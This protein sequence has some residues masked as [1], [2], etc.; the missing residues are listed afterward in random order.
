MTRQPAE[1][2]RIAVAWPM[3]RLAPVRSSV[4]RGALEVDDEGMSGSL[5]LRH[6]RPCAG[7]PRL[8]VELRKKD[9]DG[10]DEPG[11]D[12]RSGIEPQ[13]GPGLCW[14]LAAEFDAVVQAERTIVPEFKVRGRDAPAAP[15]GRARHL[16]DHKFGGDQSDRLLERKAA[17]QRLR[18]LAGP[19]PDLRL[20][21]PAGEIGVGLGLRYRRHVAAD[22]HLTA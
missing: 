19:G 14:R 16:A 4:R 6:A 1:E 12:D 2:K 20:L 10:R 15:P 13:F 22:A 21:R 18:L 9:V 17:F 5:V 11:H 3:P 8:P 7:H